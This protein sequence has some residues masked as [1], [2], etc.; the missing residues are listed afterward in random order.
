MTPPPITADDISAWKELALT[1]IAAAGVVLV[2]FVGML[3][4]VVSVV[5]SRL[6]A[7]HGTQQGQQAQL[8][9]LMLASAP[10]SASAP[11]RPLMLNHQKLADA[12]APAL[13]AAIKNQSGWPK[14]SETLPPKAP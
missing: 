13:A 6:D 1:A 14:P 5:K 8:S 10:P 9:T 7:L 2:A 12:L 11:P 3:Y 4:M